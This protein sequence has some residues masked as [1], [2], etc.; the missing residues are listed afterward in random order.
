VT[1][2]PDELVASAII[3]VTA[4]I[5]GGVVSTLLQFLFSAYLYFCPDFLDYSLHYSDSI[6]SN[7]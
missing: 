2:A 7:G 3:G 6:Y 5:V 4:S 1:V